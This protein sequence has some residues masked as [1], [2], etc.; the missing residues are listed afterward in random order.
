MTQNR[1][2]IACVFS[3]NKKCLVSKN[4]NHLRNCQGSTY[5]FTLSNA[6]LLYSSKKNPLAV[7]GLKFSIP[8]LIEDT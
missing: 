8:V 4:I 2:F 6:R 3:R 7:K 1:N 5:G